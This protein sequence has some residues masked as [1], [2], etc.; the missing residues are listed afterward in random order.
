MKS[1]KRPILKTGN[2]IIDNR[3]GNR[4][5]LVL[6]VDEFWGVVQM[7]DIK[8]NIREDVIGNYEIIDNIDLSKLEN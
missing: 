7:V 3:G 6:S 1:D 5:Y 2:V 4:K 8:G